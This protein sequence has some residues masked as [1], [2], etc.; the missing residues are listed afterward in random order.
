MA[1][2]PGR[3]QFGRD[4]GESIAAALWKREQMLL[5][6]TL[7]GGILRKRKIDQPPKPSPSGPLTNKLPTCTWFDHGAPVQSVS[8]GLA[9]LPQA[10]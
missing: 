2:L 3:S 5:L 10:P 8:G 9:P 7:V 1:V 4:R 6:V